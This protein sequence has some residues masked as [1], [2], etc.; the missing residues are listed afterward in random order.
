M[1]IKDFFVFNF[2]NHPNPERSGM[3]TR[4]A[5]STNTCLTQCLPALASVQLV[6]ASE[7]K[8]GQSSAS[9]LSVRKSSAKTA[10]IPGLPAAAAA[11]I[12]ELKPQKSQ[13][14]LHTA[15]EDQKDQKEVQTDANIGK[16]MQL[17]KGKQN[18]VR[19]DAAFQHSLLKVHDTVVT[20]NWQWMCIQR[21]WQAESG[22]TYVQVVGGTS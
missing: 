15:K 18:C 6:L 2:E 1:S 3:Q 21:S 16:C 12:T 7:P 9:H 14:L 10:K 19:L 11:W 17:L 5:M 13:T 22:S 4:A 8:K 20:Q